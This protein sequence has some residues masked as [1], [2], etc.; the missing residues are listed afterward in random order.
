VKNPD[1]VRYYDSVVRALVARGHQVELLKDSPR[2]EWPPSIRAL[3]SETGRVH[4]STLP[5]EV[6]NPWVQL[7][8]RLR[9]AR[10][11]LRFLDPARAHQNA[12][13]LERARRR[14]P[15]TAVWAGEFFGLGGTGR[16][17][18][19]RL[20]DALEESTGASALFHDFLRKKKP[21]L[22]VLSP[23]VVL[24]SAQPDF[25]R[26]A[27]ELGVRNV[28]AVASWDH[29]SSKGMMNFAPQRVFVWNET[30]KREA[31]NFHDLDPDR[32]VV[33]GSSVFDEWFG[34]QPARTRE[35]FCAHV[36]LPADRPI[37]LYVCSSLLEGSPPEP[38]FVLRWAQHLRQ[39][40]EPLLE[41]CS[42][43]IRPHPRR[44]EWR[45]VDLRS[46]GNVVCWPPTGELPVDD[47]TKNDYFDSLYHAHAVVGLNTS[48]L[49]EAAILGRPVHTILLPEFRASQ[50]GTVHFHYLLEGPDAVLRSTRSLDDH[51]RQ[52]ARVLAPEV[53]AAGSEWFVRRFVR[54][55]GLDVNATTVFVEALESL[56][57]TP[58]PAPVPRRRWTR[59][60]KPLLFPFAYAAARRLRRVSDEHRRRKHQDQV[61]HRR[62][63]AAAALDNIAR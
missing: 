20:I 2:H 60:V 16:R 18:L 19:A 51:A 36:G 4:L 7:A 54:P 21:D 8:M 42:I 32:V 58:A 9:Q 10:G 61:D 33:T 6:T 3:E 24:K 23:L 50:E 59:A 34:R 15:R 56:A 46:L 43:L 63:K 62:R 48:V 40:G 55:H 57:A 17:W 37:L 29:L 11:Y 31:I 44:R 49:I 35:A 28:V 26:A 39:S 14:A 25:A 27:C 52:L 13:L 12:A 30:Q 5:V 47:A 38:P 41:R 45:N 1:Y 53:N 22:V